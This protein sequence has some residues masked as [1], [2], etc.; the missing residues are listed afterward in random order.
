MNHAVI[1]ISQSSHVLDRRES[2]MPS[3]AGFLELIAAD[4]SAKHSDA[5]FLSAEDLQDRQGQSCFVVGNVD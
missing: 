3:I 1:S 4:Q 2:H 5:A